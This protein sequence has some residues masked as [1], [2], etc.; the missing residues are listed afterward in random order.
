[1]S[2]GIMILLIF[3]LIALL[4]GSTTALALLIAKRVREKKEREYTGETVDTVV[5]FRPGG[6]DRPA[7][8]YVR[9]EVDGQTY[10]CRETVKLKCESIRIG[11]LPIGRRKAAKIATHVGSRARVAYLPGD[12]PKTIFADNTG[13][14]NK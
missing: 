11:P 3:S 8:V 9:Y 5:R 13:L 4:G 2:D 14:M 12:P 1:M 6:V 7:S 10:E